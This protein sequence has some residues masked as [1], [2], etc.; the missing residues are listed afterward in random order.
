MAGSM[1]VNPM[2]ARA[3][4]GPQSPI[5][6]SLGWEWGGY[7]RARHARPALVP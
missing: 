6:T 2:V 7:A 5:P 1:P 4:A 3:P